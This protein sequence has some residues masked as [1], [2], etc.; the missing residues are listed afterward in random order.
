VTGQAEDNQVEQAS[1]FGTL[2]LGGALATLVSFVIGN[3]AEA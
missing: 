3:A 1:R 2:N